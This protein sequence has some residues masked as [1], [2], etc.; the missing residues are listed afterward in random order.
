M[1]G[2]K[3]G[4][5]LVILGAVL[6]AIAAC[7]KKGDVGGWTAEVEVVN[8]IRT[9]RNP[10]IPRYGDFAFDLV[11]DLAIG[12]E[13][14]EAY[15]FP[16]QA[17]VNIDDKGLFYICDLGNRRVQVYGRDG[18]FIR[19]LGRQGQ[20][21]GEFIYPRYVQFDEVGNIFINDA[22]TLAI[23]NHEGLFLKKF[24]PKTLLTI[25]MPGPGGT[26]IGTPQPIPSAEGGPMNELLQLGPDG[27]RL[28]TL[29]KFPVY[30]VS[31]DG[32]LQHWYTG[33]ISY[34]R[35][36]ADSIY[37]GFSQEYRIRAVDGEGRVLLDFSKLEK[38]LAI[39]AEEEKTT[40]EKGPFN[41]Q[42]RGD[43]RKADLGLPDHRPFFS[44]FFVDDEG[45]LYVVR[46]GSILE[47]E[48]PARE[49]DVFSYDGFYLYKMT[50]PFM[51]QVVKDGFLYQVRQDE[52]AG[53]TR[54]VRYKIKNWDDFRAK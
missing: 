25:P 35:R 20:G 48:N 24:I 36:S 10:E 14:D 16:G 29:A 27:D 1:T 18:R 9:V 43:A 6:M 31:K 11:E 46:L 28:R 39:T 22:L 13:K 54:I 33:G 47:M 49:V 26:I 7:S 23:F 8:G 5:Y 32:I 37:Y 42:G 45:R 3:A 51:P 52:E 12:D 15:F 2:T 40:R 17:T 34:C 50:L 4:R 19:T 44:R 21:P 53:D 30:G 38:A 41:W